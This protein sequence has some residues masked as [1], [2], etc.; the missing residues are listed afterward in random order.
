MDLLK[1]LAGK[2]MANFGVE[3]FRYILFAGSA[4]LLFYVLGRRAL[5]RFKIQ[6][7]FPE[8]KHMFR[9]IKYSFLSLSIFALNGVVVI[10]LYGKGYTK[11]YMTFSDHSAGYFI[12]S[13]FAFIV[14]HDTYFYWSHRLLH[15]KKIYAVVHKLHHLSHDPTPWAAYAFHPL[16]AVVQAAIF[17]I[18]V[19]IIPVHPFALLAWGLYQVFLN[20]MGHAGFELFPSGFTSGKITKWH[21]TA[22]HHN[23]HHKYANSN[24]GLYFNFWDRLMGT[25]HVKYTEQFEEVKTRAQSMKNTGKTAPEEIGINPSS[26]KESSV[27]V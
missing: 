20:V 7:K 8:K 9:E 26:I 11:L 22:T 1:D 24:Y 2:F 15:V 14:A 10:Y 16:E 21:N 13:V 5:V 27:S 4:F 17:P 19:F 23:M 18:M 25:N 3:S 6:Q 12:F